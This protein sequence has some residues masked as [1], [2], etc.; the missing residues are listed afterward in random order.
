MRAVVVVGTPPAVPPPGAMAEEEEEEA[1]TFVL[2]VPFT[3]LFLPGDDVPPPLPPFPPP[4][5]PF[6]PPLAPPPPEEEEEEEGFSV[7]PKTSQMAGCASNSRDV[8][9]VGFLSS[10]LGGAARVGDKIAGATSA[11]EVL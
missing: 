11:A 3:L 2:L 8:L 1:G 6:P 9:Q 5:A 10:R 7:V 4:L